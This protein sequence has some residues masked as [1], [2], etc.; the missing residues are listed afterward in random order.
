MI[1]DMIHPLTALMIASISIII[2]LIFFYPERGILA[3]WR[4]ARKNSE[5]VLI[6]DALKHI[7]NYEYNDIDCTIHS[8]AGNLSISGDRASKLIEKLVS[9]GLIESDSGRFKL[10]ANGRSYALRVIRVHRLWERYLADKTSIREKD[11]HTEAE[12]KEH[13]ISVDEAD[14]L[15]AR[16]GHPLIDP[17]GDPI[18]S[19]S[20][21]MVDRPGIPLSSMPQDLYARIV[22]IEDEPEAIYAQLVALGLHPG[23]QIRIIEQ[24][25]NKII[26]EADGNECVLAPLFASQ[27]HVT[28]IHTRDDVQQNF[29]PLSTLHEGERAEVVSISKKIRGEQRRRLMDLGLVPGTMVTA[30]MKSFGNDPVAYQIRGAVIALR[31]RQT[32]AIF[33]QRTDEG[34]NGS[35][36]QL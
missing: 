5:R 7:Y 24:N 23:M 1:E 31:K 28:P 36:E 3:L 33:I 30:V 18:P 35:Y 22:H 16:L 4:R 14:H 19:P 25:E 10:T 11:W 26:F 32:D 27:I 20:G 13:D 6:E 17:H 15:A 12:S 9:L 34:E 8:I 2:I 29:I 21:T